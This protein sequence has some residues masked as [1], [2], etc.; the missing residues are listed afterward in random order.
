[1]SPSPRLAAVLTV[2]IITGVGVSVLAASGC[3]TTPAGDQQTVSFESVLNGDTF[4]TKSGMIVHLHGVIAPRP[5]EPNY[6]RSTEILDE[7]MRGLP[8]KGARLRIIVLSHSGEIANAWVFAM[9]DAVNGTEAVMNGEALFWG[10]ARIDR[11]VNYDDALSVRY[12]EMMEERE[13]QASLFERGV[14]TPF[15]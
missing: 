11:T 3:A 7:R 5:G 14:W 13:R 12:R 9:A 6:L 15:D 4:R 1:M 8:D 10:S 2:A